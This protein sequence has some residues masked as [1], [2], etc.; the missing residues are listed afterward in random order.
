METAAKTEPRQLK[1]TTSSSSSLPSNEMLVL[2]QKNPTASQP[3]PTTKV[4]I[5]STTCLL[6]ALQNVVLCVKPKFLPGFHKKSQLLLIPCPFRIF[7]SKLV[8]LVDF[9]FR[10]P[11]NREE[12]IALT[13]ADAI[14]LVVHCRNNKQE[15]AFNV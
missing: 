3:F 2:H 11:S 8:H 12:Q 4:H 10:N 5:C 13:Q 6:Q 9:R 14:I 15:R 1:N 7:F